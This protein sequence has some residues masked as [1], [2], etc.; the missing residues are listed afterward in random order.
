MATLR[1]LGEEAEIDLS[2]PS[3]PEDRYWI[4]REIFPKNAIMWSFPLY[5]KLVELDMSLILAFGYK[6][7]FPNGTICSGIAQVDIEEDDDFRRLRIRGYVE[8]IY[9]YIPYIGIDRRDEESGN[10]KRR[11]RARK[12][13]LKFL[14]KEQAEEFKKR[15]GFRY[16]EHLGDGTKREWFFW[17][18]YHYPVTC[19]KNGYTFRL[20][21]DSDSKMPTEDLLLLAYLH[22]K[23]GRG[24]E[25]IRMGTQGERREMT[26]LLVSDSDYNRV[27]LAYNEDI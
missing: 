23:G 1:M 8:R 19:E 16:E 27:A 25:L 2:P 13:L 17:N 9:S 14:N 20:C 6:L 12:L 22:V 26:G 24:D 3:N 4:Y 18:T 5:R 7:V 15:G 21:F 11:D 10:R